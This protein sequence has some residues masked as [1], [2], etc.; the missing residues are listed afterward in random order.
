MPSSRAAQEIFINTPD[1]FLFSIELFTGAHGLCPQNK[2][3]ISWI[4]YEEDSI[5]FSPGIYDNLCFR[6]G[7][8][9]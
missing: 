5:T 8:W 7:V 4:Q 6:E 2:P 9:V 3:F 1:V